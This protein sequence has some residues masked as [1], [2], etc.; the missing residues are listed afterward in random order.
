M[1]TQN[2]YLK[3]QR[4]R[5]YAEEDTTPF[6]VVTNDEIHVVGDANK[7]EKKTHDYIM[8]FYFPSEMK[9]KFKK[10]DIVREDDTHF[11]VEMEFKDVSITPRNHVQAITALMELE[12]FFNKILDN[13]DV[14]DLSMEEIR[15][16]LRY[17]NDDMVEA[18][19]E[20]VASVIGVDKSIRKY[21]ALPDVIFTAAM[22][23]AD[24][25]E[26][27]NEANQLFAF[28]AERARKRANR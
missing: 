9:A 15:E 4:A 12:P 8:G 14:V 24:F 6:A 17:M 18:L 13:G 25:P 21:M 11:L 28:S 3:L 2:D 23:T 26:A 10:E 22:L 1:I 16:L 27:I 7:T 20:A 5:A 19:Y